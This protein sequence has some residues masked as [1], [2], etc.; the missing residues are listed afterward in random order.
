MGVAERCLVTLLED[1]FVYHGQA[2]A[3]RGRDQW[4]HTSPVG[5]FSANSFGLHDLPGNVGEWVED[6]YASSYSGVHSSP[7]VDL[8]PLPSLIPGS[9][10]ILTQVNV[11]QFQVCFSVVRLM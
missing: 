5:R 11:R 10:S 6:C 3:A 1:A 2:W 4:R 9:A 8:A 7:L